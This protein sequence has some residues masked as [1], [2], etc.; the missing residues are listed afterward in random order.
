MAAL[1]SVSVRVSCKVSR[2]SGNLICAN[3]PVSKAQGGTTNKVATN[4]L[5]ARTLTQLAY[6]PLTFSHRGAIRRSLKNAVFARLDEEAAVK[7]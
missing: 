6:E 5:P 4:F 7:L 1:L 2:T 3:D